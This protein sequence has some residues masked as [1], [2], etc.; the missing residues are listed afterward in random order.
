MTSRSA[1]KSSFIKKAATFRL[2]NIVSQFLIACLLLQTFVPATLASP[3]VAR[4]DDSSNEFLSS[5]VVA[6]T[7]GFAAGIGTFAAG[8]FAFVNA[9]LTPQESWNVVLTPVTTDFNN[10]TGIDYHQP[11]KKLI[12][13]SNSPV[14]DPHSFELIAG[15]GTHSA[16]SN[17]AGLQGEVLVTAARD[18]AQG[19]SLGGFRAGDLMA[20]T[21]TPGVVARISANGASVQNPWVVLPEETGHITGLHVDRTGI[22][23]GDLLVTTAAGGV[24]RVNSAGVPTRVAMLG[25]RLAGVTVVPADPERY[26][27]WAGKAIVGAKE[28]ASV[29]AVDAQGQAD[30]L[31]VGINPQ[32]IDIVPAHENFYAIDSASRKILGATEGAFAGIIGDILVTQGSPGR[33]SRVRWDGA[34]FVI[35]TLAEASEFKQV[36]FSPAGTGNIPAVKQIYDKIAVVRHAPSLDSGRVEGT[37]WQLTGEN[38]ELNGTDTITSDLLV[39]GTPTVRAADPA[40]YGGTVEGTEGTQ[41]SGY[42]LNISGR[43][44]V[45]H[46]VTRTD[47]IELN[48]VPLPPT[49]AGTRDVELR[50]AGESI[51]DPATLRNL[52]ISGNVGSVVVPPG[53]YGKFTV[54][55][56][57]VLVFGV[58]NS[59]EPTV[60]NLEELALTGGSELRLA[61][62]VT[63]RVRNRVSLV[64]ATV[65][66]SDDPKRM[67]LE[68]A[69][70][71][72]GDALKISGNAVL[73]GIV[74]APQGDITIEGNG[75]LRG[76]VSCDYLFVNGNG[77][78]QITE[79]DIPPPPVNRPPSVD[80]G[81]THTIT[82][83]TDTATLEGTAS[84]DGLPTGSTLSVAWTKVSGPGAVTFAN[85]GSA[86][87][88]AT[89]VE[90]GEYVLKLTASDGQ[91]SSSDTT[92][93]T[94]IPRNQPPTVDAGE[95]QTIEMPALAELR[96]TVSDDA[97]P[98][99]S[100][101]TPTWS[102]V[103]GPGAVVFADPHAAAT[104][105]AFSAPGTYTLRLSAS[106]T[107]FTVSDDVI[108]TVLKNDPPVVN[109]G[110]DREIVLPD[111]ITLSGT[112][113]DDG[114]PTGSTLEVSW[115]QISGPAPIIFNDA[116]AA[117]TP[118]SFSAPGTY[119]LR[120]T[121]SDSQLSASDEVTINV[122]PQPFTSRTYTFDAD[123]N[124]G[125][126][127]SL[128]KGAGNQL[129]LDDTTQSF[130]FIWVAVS[131]KG[132]VVKINTE[133]GAIIGE[134]RTSPDGQPKDPS[135]TTVDQNGNV[136]ATN[137]A[138][139]SVVHI[140]LIEN[141]QCVDRNNNGVI[142]TSTGFGDIRA[143]PN[144]NNANTNGGVTL[145]QDECIIHYTKVNSFGTRH[146]SVTKDNDV[147]VSGTNGQRF[148]LIDGKTGLIK[149][150]EPS[151]GYGGYGGLIDK[152][153][154]IWSAR[155]L[156]RWDT[157]KPLTGRNALSGM[158]FTL[159]GGRA[160]WDRAG[161]SSTQPSPSERV[162]VEDRPPAG[163]ALA[164]DG[165][166]WNWVSANPTPFSGTAAHQSNIS[167]GTHQHYFTNA[168]DLL[169]VGTGDS[170]FT[171]VYLDPANPPRQVM[172]QWNNGNWEHRAYWGQSVIPWG[173]EGTESR[174]YMGPLPALGQWVKLEVPARQ[175]GL[176]G[177]GANWRGYGHDSY[178]LC[179]DSK[180][181]VW[182]TALEWNQISK[183]A[184]DGTHLG[185]FQHG[186]H[187][188]QG[189]VVDKNDNVW[190]AHSIHVASVGHLKNDGSFVGNVGVHS[191]PTGVAVDGKGKI[192]TTNH[193]TGT[194][195]R[196]DPNLGPL[197]PDGVTRVGQVDFTT[198][199]LGGTL[200]NYSDMTGSTLSGAPGTGTWS[201]VYDSKLAGAAWGRLGWTAQV[202]GDAS[203]TVSVASSENGTTF[204]VPVT[205]ANGEDPFVAN[206][207]YLK[208]NVSFKRAS[209][210]ESP[211]LY[212]LSVGTHGYQLPTPTNAAPTAFAGSDQTMTLPDAAKLV[213]TACDDGFPRGNAF[214]LS[215]SEVSGPGEVAFS[216]PNSA[217]TDA[218]FTLPGEYVL[219]LTASDG[220]HSVSDELTVT[221]LPANMAPIVNAGTNQTITLPNTA[222]L[223]GT[224]SDDGLPSGGTLSTFW[225]QLSGPAVATFNN[226]NSPVTGAVFPLPGTYTL[227][228][229]GNDSHRVGT[230][231]VVVTVNA[232]PALVGA[233]LA[234]APAASGPY[235]TG[236]MQPLSATLKN[237]SGNPLANYGVEFEVTGPNAA[238]GS[239]VTNAS[240]VAT[241]NYSGTN[242]GTDTVRALVRN[243][244]NSNVNSNAVS[245]EWT[246]TA[247][248]P[249]VVQG[250]IGG[251][252]NNST[253]T[254]IVPITVGAGV[255]LTQWTAD[256]WPA[257]NPSAVTTL[258]TGTQGS[259]G[260]TLAT[261]DPTTLANG[262][263][264]IR[265]TATDST[266]QELVSQVTVTVAG[267]NKPGRMTFS[268]TDLTVPTAGIPITIKRKYDSLERN[269][270]GD[271]GYGW[272]LEMAG[273]RLEVS[274]DHDVTIT[275]PGTGRRV[276]FNFNPTSFGFPFS[277]M[278]Q[279]TYTPEPGVY[280]KLTSDGCGTLIRTSGGAQCFLSADPTYRPTVYAYT[281][282]YGRVYTMTAAGKM[283]SIK[284]LNGNVLTFSATGITS[285]NGGLNVPFVRDAQGRITQIT[286]PDG[287]AYRYNYDAAG[288]LSAVEL[289]GM[290]TPISYT[291]AAGHFF[292][293][294]TDPRGNTEASSTYHADGRLASLTDALGNTTRYDYDLAENKTTLTYPDGG[295]ATF[296]YAANG[297]LLSETD[298]LNHTTTYTYDGKRNKLTE[299]NALQ[300][301]TTHTYDAGGN[302]ASTTDPA[303]KTL[304]WTYNSY[305]MPVTATDQ[306]GKTQ[307]TQ[308]DAAFNPVSIAD[309]VGT[310]LAFTWDS[311][312]NPLTS[313][314]GNGKVTRFTYD[315]YGN[316]LTKVDPLGRTI[317]YTYDGMGRVVTMTDARGTTRSTYDA[318][319]RL[320]TL[321]DPLNQVTKYEYD[322]NGNKTAQV[323][324][325]GR[326]T[327][328][329]YDAAN[330]VK[331]VTNPDS[332]VLS[333]TYNFRGQ[334]LTE[335]D[336]EGHTTT[337]VYDKAGRRV[338]V[339]NP[340][341]TEATLVYDEVGRLTSETDERNQTTRYEYDQGCGCRE[342]LAKVIDPLGGV[343]SYGFDAAGRRTSEIDANQRETRFDYDL[344]NRLVQ[345]TYADGKTTKQT[346]DG[347]GRKLTETDQAGRVTRFA[348]DEVG[349]LASVTDALNQTTVNSYDALNNLQSTT[350]ALGRTTRFEY[351]GLNRIIKRVL[352]L[353]MAEL[354]TYDQVGNRVTRTDFRGKLTGYDYDSMNRLVKK[355]PDASLGE[356]SVSY[357]Y[358]PAGQRA[359]MADASGMTLYSYDA[360]HRLLSKQTPQGTLT[361]TYDAAGNVASTRS[362]N[363]NGL[364]VNYTYDALNRIGSVVD[365]RLDNGTTAYS[366]DAAGNTLKIT[367]ANGVQTA[368]VYDNLYRPT[369]V[370]HS[371]EG[372]L[373]SYAQTLDPTGRRLS[374]TE[375]S[376]RVVNYT[377]DA[378]YRLTGETIAGDPAA[379]ANGSVAYTL[380]PVGNRL[381]RASTLAAVL[382]AT[383]TYDA[384]D[385]QTADS[386]DANGNTRAGSGNTYA[387]DFEDHLKSVN[388]GAIRIVYDGDGN[389]MAK[390]VGGVT[391]K[392][393]VDDLSP[394][395]YSQVVEELVGG[396]VQRVYTYGQRPLSQRQQ[397]NGGWQVSFY[398]L[399]AYGSVRFLTGADGSVTDTYTYDAFG[400]MTSATGSTP[401]NYL[402]NAQ[403]YDHD[404]GLY[405]KRARYY[406]QDRG[407][408]MTMDTYAGRLGEPATLHKYMFGHADPANRID[409][410]GTMAIE[411]TALTRNI[412]VRT[413]AEATLLGIRLSC[414]FYRV[415][416]AIDSDV[417]PLIPPLF[418][419]CASDTC[420]RLLDL[421]MLTPRWPDRRRRRGYGGPRDC[422][423][424]Y[425][426]CKN[427][428][429]EW[430]FD[431]CPIF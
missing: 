238:T 385:R 186:A 347:A 387:Y 114:Y 22:F 267:E 351:D 201:T 341:L 415:A 147:W 46:V 300:Q 63:L 91:L 167:S 222:T 66:A 204:G 41:P 283:L 372:T 326:R 92:T 280:G 287:K 2:R 396:S 310:R 191:G 309:N 139:N 152:N 79:N 113:S 101:V 421:C 241:F 207:R 26:G 130:N 422:G 144:T 291:Y 356:P 355:T 52:N 363:A 380:D 367:S 24:W 15:N 257:A 358:N 173:N 127:V 182:N 237:S 239:A 53:T 230:S 242:P 213:G 251:P 314:D 365:N 73:Y 21:G 297:L 54:G 25:T 269:V 17:V 329:E 428:D 296:K 307:T 403:Q 161:K 292:R 85:A 343:T 39:P 217:V 348:Y 77:V 390:T 29:Y 192:W 56:R 9:A 102:V 162:W 325:A 275:E 417:I 386:Y 44:R 126:L 95:P 392:Y 109:A 10:H 190:V 352:P 236:T 68:V 379:A 397:R 401:N 419:S 337:F 33:V 100:T 170:L 189:C 221:A 418:K 74:R 227:R 159:N 55:G 129:Q 165:E 6:T 172:L 293:N 339:I 299:T 195:S 429:G 375:N 244:A 303:G 188:A 169:S 400:V 240:G 83:P 11:S 38:L 214:A 176:E 350:D 67:L 317:T 128:T 306:L 134:Y 235:V 305:G 377:Y 177:S 184:P 59:L 193:D 93:I 12:V 111:A 331:K 132:T 122:K 216:R 342:R 149:R 282:P 61:G 273:P 48:N 330:R 171:Y 138:G 106:D 334:R 131:S 117:T 362:S 160:T 382:S 135:R 175:V 395:G 359:S 423:E 253:V 8:V 16:F 277:F 426:E 294:S 181:N 30:I 336:Q 185:T 13:S 232:S 412:A 371:R 115:S 383:S 262:N 393:L 194:V 409:P 148:D 69:D 279:P 89:F 32:D 424:C 427:N 199:N 142:D 215:W 248:S 168:S 119:V 404:L 36:A 389:R 373:A 96:G 258:A 84:D 4:R 210:G 407:R 289:P 180:G 70:G 286:N 154:I 247:V 87:T 270:N 78:L 231:D 369:Q 335:T 250:W 205:I 405:F 243:T 1:K 58:E 413:A 265:L 27:L 72:I 163:A 19:M 136:W 411:Y 318:L 90:P 49:P 391:T 82:L 34:Q 252:L 333:Y 320:L 316:I 260:A 228:L 264:V 65:G 431:K 166:G 178:G 103:S 254:S 88:S 384:N 288:D 313:T 108:I 76:T 5:R 198:R 398:G 298:P 226:P 47:P 374:V 118:A 105:A 430:P 18:D 141:G 420:K 97:M 20:S 86:A 255:T 150:A 256:Y 285:N 98:R 368:Y 290:S 75:R 209:S 71:A 321:T 200:Y 268:V 381:S 153:G 133:T 64:G 278:Y 271:F 99:G 311:R 354:Y 274:P 179:V 315:A 45:R 157:S 110:A 145:A 164:G 137:R 378:L 249:P 43:A 57:N 51:G 233:T 272:S 124:E 81:P 155:P 158:A 211:V 223:N 304:R 203:L 35:T 346:Y 308:F 345:T 338:K 408:F 224:V 360:R 361:Y 219:R 116:F 146:V 284:D 410:C 14:G 60:Y 202:C 324:A 151:V 263:Y 7:R 402:F 399:D 187:W 123:F 319:G 394:T 276:T 37:L 42:T 312:G 245:M 183:F 3:A 50:K 357:T 332:T 80:A 340:D 425:R 376:G 370:T 212:D 107:E 416:S 140:G 246:L 62:R 120:L 364:S 104:T 327:T 143:W 301:T 174:R 344:R 208:I 261:L 322:D 94:V 40:N 23:G 225:S 125:S 259:P 295:V 353:G 28:Q 112:A 206:G 197:G 121:A 266:G 234:L 414:T 406:S 196:I 31:Q 349:N 220:Q 328:Y 156:L 302:L 366:Y 323:D 218:T 388:G 229:S 281:D